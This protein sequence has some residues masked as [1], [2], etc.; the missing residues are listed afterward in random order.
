MD[1]SLSQ[2]ALVGLMAVAAVLMG[3]LQARKS[4]LLS[5]WGHFTVAGMAA[6]FALRNEALVQWAMYLGVAAG[7]LFIVVSARK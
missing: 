6:G 5:A 2:F 1:Q 4:G 3:L 7:A